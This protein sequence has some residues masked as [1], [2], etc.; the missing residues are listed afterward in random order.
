MIKEIIDEIIRVEGGYT[1]NPNDTGGATNFGITEKVAR[2]YGYTGDM[3]FLPESVARDIYMQQYVIDPGFD[4][5]AGV[6]A[7]IGAELVD[8]GVNCGTAVAGKF[9]QQALN[10][11]ND[12]QK[13]YPDLVVDGGCGPKTLEVLKK[14]LAARGK[15]GELTM[16]KALNC[17][18]GARYI[19]ITEARP[20][21]EDFCFGWIRNRVEIK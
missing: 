8:T 15:D 7:I 9:L 21:N 10:A 4:K 12:E 2:A 16:L 20:A 14:Y 17:L 18:Q 3:K 1:N 13:Y 6:S 19:S 11:F 5:I